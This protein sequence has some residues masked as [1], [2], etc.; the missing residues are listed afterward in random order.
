MFKHTMRGLAAA[1]VLTFVPPVHA[2]ELLAWNGDHFDLLSQQTDTPAPETKASV[3]SRPSVSHAVGLITFGG[4]EDTVV[5]DGVSFRITRTANSIQV[6]S[7]EDIVR[8]AG[9][10]SVNA[11]PRLSV[12]SKADGSSTKFLNLESFG[13]STSRSTFPM[14][15]SAPVV[16]ANA[17]RSNLSAPAFLLGPGGPLNLSFPGRTT[18]MP[19]PSA[20]DFR[21][22][23]SAPAFVF[24]PS[25]SGNLS[26]PGLITT[27]PEPSAY[28]LSAI[29]AVALGIVG[30]F[31]Y[32]K[33]RTNHR[34]RSV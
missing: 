23:S 17:L 9:P 31:R 29:S 26:F 24:G 34:F 15:K 2:L 33:N 3:K 5:D 16:I 4:V 8:M 11:K 13:I 28:V 12:S 27:V 1:I 10:D 6:P 20:Y 18:T 14:P 7:A 30:R 19:G 25:G 32:R 21:S 22:N